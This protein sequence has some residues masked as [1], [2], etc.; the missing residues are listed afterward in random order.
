MSERLDYFSAM[1]AITYLLWVLVMRLFA[2]DRQ[3]P[4]QQQEGIKPALSCVAVLLIAFYCH[5]VSSLLQHFDY[6]YNMQVGV[7]IAAVNAVGWGRYMYCIRSQK[8]PHARRMALVFLLLNGA[9][10][11]EVLDFPPL[12]QLLDA[13]AAW[14]LVTA[15][16]GVAWYKCLI[17]DLRYDITVREHKAN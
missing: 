7:G 12:W 3:C 16:L 6:G 2:A 10:I 14:H 9:V 5:H 4:A 8:R 17:A 15:P 11:L 1:L 13:H